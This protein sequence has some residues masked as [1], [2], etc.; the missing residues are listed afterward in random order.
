MSPKSSGKPFHVEKDQSN[1]QLSAYF[2]TAVVLLV[3]LILQIVFLPIGWEFDINSPEFNPLIFVPLLLIAGVLWSLFNAAR[4]WRHLRRFGESA[5]ELHERKSLKPGGTCRGRIRTERPLHAI[6]DYQITL[7]CIE[8]HHFSTAR[9]NR[10]TRNRIQYVTA[11]EKTL[12]TPAGEA[13]SS[14]GLPFEF[15]LPQVGPLATFIEPAKNAPYFKMKISLNIPGLK[16]H[17]ITH[18]APPSTRA[19]WLEMEVST[20]QGR[21]R[22]QFQVPVQE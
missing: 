20:S 11:W 12:S 6:G 16:R 17:V 3:F 22:T 19:W 14:A 7:R 9:G 21:F 5:M 2:W 13:D 8:G 10:Q 15:E 1:S 4:H 18:N